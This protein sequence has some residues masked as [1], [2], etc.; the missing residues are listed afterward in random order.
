MQLPTLHIMISPRSPGYGWSATLL[1]N[2]PFGVG[3][4]ATGES[5][6]GLLDR[7]RGMAEQ[8]AE[9]N[10]ERAIAEYPPTECLKCG[11]AVNPATKDPFCW[12]CRLCPPRQESK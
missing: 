3:F 5:P 10:G 12:N 8:H 4:Q 2:E 7:L 1:N 11:S 9:L 6:A